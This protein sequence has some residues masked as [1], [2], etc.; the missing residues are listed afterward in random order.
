MYRRTSSIHLCML[1]N[2]ERF[3]MSYTVSAH[4]LHINLLNFAIGFHLIC[5]ITYDHTIRWSIIALCYGPES[6]LSYKS[7]RQNKSMKH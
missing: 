2:V 4:N 5:D 7:K 6:F 3:V 1:R